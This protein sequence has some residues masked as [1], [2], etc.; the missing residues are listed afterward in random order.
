[1]AVLTLRHLLR[2]SDADDFAAGIAAFRAELNIPVGRANH[3]EVVVEDVGDRLPPSP[4]GVSQTRLAG[5]L[6]LQNHVA[7]AAAVAVGAAE[8]DVAEELH[9]DVLEAVPV[10][11]GAP[12]FTAVEAEGAG[13]VAA[14]FGE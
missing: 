7:I 8:V 10:T 1:M 3:I 13:A 9:F 6:H 4:L 12:A 11:G 5:D 2:C 14:F